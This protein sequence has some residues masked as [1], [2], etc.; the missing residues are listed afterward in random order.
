MNHQI[1]IKGKAYF[2]LDRPLKW[3]GIIDY[4]TL[5]LFISFV[6]GIWKLCQ[7]IT[8]SLIVQIYATLI[9][10]IPFVIFLKAYINEIDILYMIVLVLRFCFMPHKFDYDI[11]KDENN[12]IFDYVKDTL[13]YSNNSK[14][15]KFNKKKI[16]K[17]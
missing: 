9:V 12:I 1:D 2:G 13:V 3:N 15:Y 16:R 14:I 11:V 10:S 6:V 7:I 17:S 4:K 5:I 8:N